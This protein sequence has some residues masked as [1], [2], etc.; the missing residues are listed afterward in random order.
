VPT[1]WRLVKTK[2]AG[3]AFDGEGARLYGGRWSSPGVRVA[4]GSGSVA[5]AILEVLVHL[6]AARLLTS[7]SIVTAEVP[8]ELV[9]VLPVA[10]LPR[11]WKQSPPPVE[12][13][14]IGDAWVR[15]ATS[16]ALAVPSAIV[17]TERNYLLNP[18]HRSFGRIR[19]AAPLRFTFDPRLTR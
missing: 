14:A 2:Y 6:D 13:R 10:E 3:T 1:V 17:E 8:D 16:A 7:Y 15:A 9:T 12:T 19:I 18:A 4:Y 5:L 11:S